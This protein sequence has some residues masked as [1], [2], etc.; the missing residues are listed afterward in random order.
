MK[1]RKNM[2]L[3]PI[4]EDSTCVICYNH[5]NPNRN[6]T[7]TEC[8]HTFCSK[9]IFEWIQ[10]NAIAPECPVC[11]TSLTKY[12]PNLS[13]CNHDNPIRIVAEST[14]RRVSD[15][16]YMEYLIQYDPDTQRQYYRI[17]VCIQIIVYSIVICIGVVFSY[18]LCVI[19]A[20]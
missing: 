18:I 8:K 13:E 19:V 12:T 2:S 14:E 3:N 1:Y 4:V 16:D 7:K 11:R 9:C 6:Y 10:R 17:G 20:T 15:F 5:I